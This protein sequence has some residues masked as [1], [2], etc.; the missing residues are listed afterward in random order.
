M[1]TNIRKQKCNIFT[2]LKCVSN[3][4]T[5]PIPDPSCSITGIPV[6]TGLKRRFHSI[7]Q[8]SDRGVHLHFNLFFSSS[9]NTIVWLFNMISD[10]LQYD[11]LKTVLRKLS[12]LGIVFVLQW[13]LNELQE[14][15]L[16]K[17]SKKC[18]IPCEVSKK[19]S[20]LLK[21]YLLIDFV[22]F[23]NEFW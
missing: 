1:L 4:Q 7:Y 9:C 6:C 19:N 10:Y 18:R 2:R 5:H 20:L 14:V 3:C 17:R 12:K 8:S 21:K 13:K 16:G 11:F 15:W 22:T 23:E